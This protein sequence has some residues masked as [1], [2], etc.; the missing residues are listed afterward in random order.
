MKQSK[1]FE[2]DSKQKYSLIFFTDISTNISRY[3]LLNIK[4]YHNKKKFKK[5]V[6]YID[7]SVYELS[8]SNEYSKVNIMHEYLEN[9]LL[10]DNE[11]ISIDYPCDMNEQYT[12]LFIRKSYQNNVKYK[13]NLKYIC[14]I[15][16][17]FMD[18]MSFIYEVERL[19]D[20]WEIPGKIIGIGNMC[21]I[22][23]PNSFTNNV[24]RYIR[25]NMKDH[26]IHFYGL[27]L[28]VLKSSHFKSL[29]YSDF[30]ISVD[31][32]KWTRAVNSFLKS[33]Y[34]TSCRVNNRDEFFLEYMKTLE[35][36]GIKVEY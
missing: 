19:K 28:R 10:L 7:P 32:T 30:Q 16:F 15:Q 35:K 2:I 20:I 13:N 26:K 34:K 27:S 36:E 6:C 21:R 23:K 12:E 1:L 14:T 3:C 24:M 31:S 4:S 9:N 17:K 11:Y 29:L 18:Y 25:N 33:K 5:T 8:K 22:M